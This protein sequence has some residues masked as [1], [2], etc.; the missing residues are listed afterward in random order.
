MIAL[1]SGR[2]PLPMLVKAKVV[3]TGA[4]PARPVRVLT[5]SPLPA[6]PALL[7]LQVLLW[8]HSVLSVSP[9][10]SLSWVAHPS[11]TT[12]ALELPLVVAP[13]NVPPIVSTLP[14]TP[15]LMIYVDS[16]SALFT[17]TDKVGLLTNCL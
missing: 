5:R 16:R 14:S 11:A 3:P 2:F 8:L 1:K 6:S 7:A 13:P 9:T 10:R 17:I 4:R 15:F 12:V